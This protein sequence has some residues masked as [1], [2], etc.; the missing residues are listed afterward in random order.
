LWKTRRWKN[1]EEVVQ[2]KEEVGQT[3]NAS[4]G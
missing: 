2:V 3:E 4:V 1:S